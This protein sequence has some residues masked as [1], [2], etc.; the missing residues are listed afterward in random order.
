MTLVKICGLQEVE[1]VRAAVDAGADAIGFVFAKSR[2]Q[3]T[4]SHAQRMTAVVPQDVLKVGVFVNETIEY[5]EKYAKEVPLDYVQLHGDESI[6]YVNS[7]SVPVIKAF[8]ISSKEDVQYA[9]TYDVDLYLFDTPSIEFRGGSGKTF[10]WGLLNSEIPLKEKVILAGGLNAEN[11]RVAI[12]TVRP[13]M[14][15]VSSGVETDQ[16]KDA[17]KIH[18]FIREVRDEER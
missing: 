10:D 11:V 3:V 4:L 5:I 16:R 9:L 2:R 7:I 17:S 14:V 8:S 15:D 1:H 6:E 18:A 12:Q 13:Y